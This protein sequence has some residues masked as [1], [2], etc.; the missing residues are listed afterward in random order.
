MYV[1]GVIWLLRL[2]IL[3]PTKLGA[4]SGTGLFGLGRLVVRFLKVAFGPGWR[5][6]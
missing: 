1:A 5:I 3:A 6:A 2:G 4:A